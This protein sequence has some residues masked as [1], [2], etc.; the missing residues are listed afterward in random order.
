MYPT[1]FIR[2][3]VVLSEKDPY[4]YRYWIGALLAQSSGNLDFGLLSGL[5]Y[6]VVTE[7]PLLITSL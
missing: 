5:P 6:E 3:D 7:E 1:V 4:H 2:N